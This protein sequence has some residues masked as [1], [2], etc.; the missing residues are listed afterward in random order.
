MKSSDKP[1][2][3]YCSAMYP[4][5]LRIWICWGCFVRSLYSSSAA[6]ELHLHHNG[7]LQCPMFENSMTRTINTGASI[8]ILPVNKNDDAHSQSVLLR[9]FHN[10]NYSLVP[11]RQ[12]ALGDHGAGAK[13]MDT[14]SNC[15]LA[16]RALPYSHQGVD[17]SAAAKLQFPPPPSFPA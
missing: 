11:A 4:K 10:D 6:G 1:P 16:L 8:F 13:P 7:E 9:L 3:Q 15:S 17:G 14:T 5:I 12:R 2:A